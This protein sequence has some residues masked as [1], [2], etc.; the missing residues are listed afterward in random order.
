MLKKRRNIFWLKIKQQ[1]YLLTNKHPV[2][3][4]RKKRL[5][6]NEKYGFIN[7]TTFEIT[8]EVT[9]S[10]FL[11]VIVLSIVYNFYIIMCISKKTRRYYNITKCH[12]FFHDFLILNLCLEVLSFNQKRFYSCR[13]RFDRNLVYTKHQDTC[14]KMH[15]LFLTVLNSKSCLMVLNDVFFKDFD[16]ILQK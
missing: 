10:A 13:K 5:F 1:S 2:A 4:T 7:I 12:R 16:F 6:R 3:K 9:I 8:M 15:F 11:E 14:S